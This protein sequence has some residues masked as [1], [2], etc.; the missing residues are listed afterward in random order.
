VCRVFLKLYVQKDAD[1]GNYFL[2]NSNHIPAQKEPSSK[3]RIL[4]FIC[5]LQLPFSCFL[6][7]L[8]V[9]FC[10]Y[11]SDLASRLYIMQ[12]SLQPVSVCVVRVW[13]SSVILRTFVVI[14]VKQSH[15]MPWRHM[16]GEEVQLLLI[17]NLS[18]RGGWVVS[19]T[20]QPC[21]TL[22]ERAPSTHWTGGWVGPRAS[23]DAETRR[24]ILCLCRGSNR[25]SSP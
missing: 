18:T 12:D 4:H 6:E 25:L 10:K 19:I 13:G 2:S 16:G 11:D 24:K 7:N 3:T 5:I 21:F 22:R 15:Y 17:L 1:S 23:L 14:K 9:V 8:W 20:S